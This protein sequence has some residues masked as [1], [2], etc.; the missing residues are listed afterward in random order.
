MPL[1]CAARPTTSSPWGAPNSV[2][3]P[4]GVVYNFAH[5]SSDGLRV[6]LN[7]PASMAT[8]RV[9]TGE[10]TSRSDGFGTLLPIPN[11]LLST[12]NKDARWNFT[13]DEIYLASAPDAA[14]T[15]IYIS[16]LE[17]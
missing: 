5:F 17:F 11:L 1:M 2:S 16:I 13:E 7:N 15:D 3:L 8:T 6:L 12:R 14:D 10:R 4:G 9:V